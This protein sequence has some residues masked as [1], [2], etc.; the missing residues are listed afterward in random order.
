MRIALVVAVVVGTVAAPRAQTVVPVPEFGR[1]DPAALSCRVTA[2]A[3]NRE[4]RLLTVEVRNTGLLA[5]E[6]LEFVIEAKD[7]SGA[8]RSETFRRVQ[9]PLARRFGRPVPPGGKQTY[10]VAVTLP[11]AR[12]AKGVRVAA[13]AW[14]HGGVVAAP[15]LRLGEPRSVSRSSLAGTFPVTEVELQN[16]FDR[17]V[18]LLLRVQLTQPRDT[19][20]LMGLRLAAGQRRAWILPSLPGTVPYL[21]EAAVACPMR[22]TAFELVDWSL[23]APNDAA[24]AAALLQPAYEAA[25]RWPAA[26]QAVSGSFV[27]RQR[28]QRPNAPGAYDEA[29]ARG[30]YTLQRGAEPAVQFDGTALSGVTGAIEAAFEF[31]AWPEWDEL[32]R[33][34]EL[35]LVADDRVELRGS[36]WGVP[37]G[38]AASTLTTDG[39]AAS[40]LHADLAIAGDR[41]VS[42]GFGD[43]RTAWELRATDRRWLVVRTASTS[44]VSTW[45]YGTCG[46]EFVPVQWSCT[47]SFGGVVAS[48]ERLELGAPTF[49]EHARVAPTPPAGA[50][51]PMLRAAWD[52]GCRLPAAPLAIEAAFVANNP[53]TDLG[54]HGRKRVAGRFTATGFGRHM[55]SFHV[56]F[57]D[58]AQAEI[59]HELAFLLRDRLLMW[60]GREFADRL[61]FDEFFAGATIDGPQID[62]SFAIAGGPVVSVATAGGLVR[63][64]R[65]ADGAEVRLTWST[66]GGHEVVQRWERQHPK[67]GRGAPAWTETMVVGWTVVDQLPWPTSIALGQIFGR[68]FGTETITLKNLVVK[69]AR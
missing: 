3:E 67:A 62:G 65:T 35:V 29:E 58:A 10:V 60:W 34:N 64:W 50:G 56:A 45:A 53:G 36:G 5:A 17:D 24:A 69:E 57:D 30:R 49:A 9:A 47:Q 11:V 28:R 15:D 48:A 20:V 54:W 6:P 33:R 26:V 21:D 55:Q 1:G 66:V 42:R 18:D 44:I 40:V 46:G 7:T 61:P 2:V 39:G 37:R 41:I 43:L 13:A 38:G 12:G 63:G 59:E 25:Y 19:T 51:A 8:V 23:V 22:A 16:P 32:C 52:R 68:E 31:V 4:Q 27:F 14:C